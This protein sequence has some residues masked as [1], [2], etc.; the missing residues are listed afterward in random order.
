MDDKKYQIFI[1]STYTDLIEA[2]DKIIETVLSL[3]HFP[4]GME[5][6]SADDS[7]QWEIIQETIN[8]SDYYV[9]IIGHRYGSVASDGISYTEKE[10]DYAREKGLPI[11]AFIRDRN[12]PTLPKER[13]ESTE[14]TIKLEAFIKKATA[15]KMC[16]FWV[17]IDDLATK[18]A[19]A[20]PKIFR[21]TPQIGWVKGSEAISKEISQELAELST[22]N[23]ELRENLKAMESLINQVEPNIKV[24]INSSD[25]VSIDCSIFCDKEITEIPS[26]ILKNEIPQ[27][28]LEFI[29]DEDI[30][31]Y[32]KK[33]PSKDVV[34]NYNE[35]KRRYLFTKSENSE[36]KFEVSNVG[37]S[38]ANDIFVTLEFPSII[39]VI[40]KDQFDSIIELK[41]KTPIPTSLL[42]KAEREYKKKNT[43][44]IFNNMLGDRLATVTP[45]HHLN[46]PNLTRFNNDYW[47]SVKDNK[48]TLKLNNLIHTRR[49]V[50]GN[51][52]FMMPLEE[53][54]G[55]IKVSVICEEY[56]QEETFQIPIII[57]V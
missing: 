40:E 23:R 17:N 16:D 25:T 20:L 51:E 39:K 28:L 10:Y 38:K 57:K 37:K 31:I 52:L 24:K 48:V 21:R 5:M 50:F 12:I 19:I 53:G 45:N 1:S 26:P 46:I 42:V 22:E 35:S 15:S 32:N 9:I 33:L 56:K 4:V 55:E 27:H 41:I 3:Y 54:E 49:R 8:V 30:E 47:S 29:S 13:E 2:R 44:P 36:L 43:H 11:L 6:F 34:D 7:E 14:A 18:V